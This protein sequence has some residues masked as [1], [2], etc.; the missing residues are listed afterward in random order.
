[1][2]DIISI[3]KLF[4]VIFITLVMSCIFIVGIVLLVI[5]DSVID[6]LNRNNNN[7]I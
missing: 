6:F 2:N 1:M 5:A 7:H 3:L 4:L